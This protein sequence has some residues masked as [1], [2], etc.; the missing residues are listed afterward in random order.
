MARCTLDLE[1]PYFKK[2]LKKTGDPDAALAALGHVKERI[3]EDHEQ[4]NL[5]PQRFFS[6]NKYTHLHNKVW[7]YD[8]APE[9]VTSHGRK[10][11][12]MIVIVPDPNTIPYRMIAGAI[13]SKSFRDSLSLAEL[14]AIYHGVMSPLEDDAADAASENFHR[15]PN[16]DGA[17]RS[18]CIACLEWNFV[19]LESTAIDSAECEHAK[20]CPKESPKN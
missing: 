11:W 8:W 15:M 10:T 1:N 20:I 14:A 9:G 12:R 7:R 3:E 4:C 2:S 17:T 19:H 6:N 18:M 16:G 5:V 13:Y